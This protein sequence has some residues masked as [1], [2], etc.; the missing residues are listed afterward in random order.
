MEWCN[1]EQYYADTQRSR[2][3]TCGVDTMNKP[4]QY[5]FT[6]MLLL[7][8]VGISLRQDGRV[9][10]HVVPEAKIAYEARI[11]NT[12]TLHIVDIPEMKGTNLGDISG[13][14]T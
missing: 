1:P 7:L 6:F 10:A 13:F 3:R 5:F 14:S 8:S 12:L 9:L 4:T 2:V 11:N